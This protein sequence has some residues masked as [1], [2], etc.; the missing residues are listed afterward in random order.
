MT[1]GGGARDVDFRS[2]SLQAEAADDFEA[3]RED[4][5]MPARAVRLP[6]DPSEEE[7]RR[8]ALT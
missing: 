3:I 2:A 8:H 4:H 7:Q 5:I 6:L 1:T